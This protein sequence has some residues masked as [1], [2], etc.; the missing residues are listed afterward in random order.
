MKLLLCVFA[1]ALSLPVGMKT[2]RIASAAILASITI[3]ANGYVA[4]SVHKPIDNTPKISKKP[5]SSSA[6]TREIASAILR[7]NKKLPGE[8]EYT[9]TNAWVTPPPDTMRFNL[10]MMNLQHLYKGISRLMLILQAEYA[11]LVLDSENIGNMRK[12]E[13]K[14]GGGLA[15]LEDNGMDLKAYTRLAVDRDIAKMMSKAKTL[16]DIAEVRGIK[17]QDLLEFRNFIQ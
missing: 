9:P 6:P 5:S 13:K 4:A 16:V 17:L 14:L 2:A 15:M 10:A 12:D 1:T 8:Y 11:N 7:E 3:P